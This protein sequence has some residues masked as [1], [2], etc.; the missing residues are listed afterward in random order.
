MRLISLSQ[1]KWRTPAQA[2]ESGVITVVR[3]PFA[4]VLDGE[5]GEP[6][7]LNQVAP[8][9]GFAAKANEDVPMTRTGYC[10]LTTW[11][12]EHG[13]SEIE[14]YFNAGGVWV[15]SWVA[16]DPNYRCEDLR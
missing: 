9:S 3:N 1:L 8:D 2:G 5:C 16:G 14:R 15:D 11:L 13:A 7:V 6:R 4:A 10:D 12:I